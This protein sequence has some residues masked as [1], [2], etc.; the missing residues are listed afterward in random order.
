MKYDPNHT[1]FTSDYH[2]LDWKNGFLHESTEE[3]EKQHITLW[4]SAVGKDDL[5]LYIGDF[6]D[7]DTRE[8]LEDI[9]KKLNGRKILIKGNHDHLA[10]EL[11]RCA[12]EDVVNEKRIDVLNL[13]LIHVKEEVKE[14]RDGA[15]T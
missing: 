10:D 14:L 2:F 13:R 9:Q 1:F 5:V 7:G 11:Y 12:F 3:E 6:C 8:D 4:N 15:S